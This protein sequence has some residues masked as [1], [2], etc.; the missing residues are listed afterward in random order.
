[1]L[2]AKAGGSEADAT[3]PTATWQ[4]W[5]A[6]AGTLLSFGAAGWASRAPP[7]DTAATM[8]HKRE[9]RAGM[10]G[11]TWPTAPDRPLCW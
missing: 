4:Q 2:R 7:S 8:A 9:A 11:G 3:G 10:A 1:M 5:D 6:S